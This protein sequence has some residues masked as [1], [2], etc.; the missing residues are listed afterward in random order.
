MMAEPKTDDTTDL[1]ALFV[2]ARQD[3]AQMP[4]GLSARMMADA[5][6]I[7]AELTAPVAVTRPSNRRWLHLRDLLG[8]WPG[9]GGLAAACAAGVWLGFAPPALFPDP[10][11]LISQTETDVDLFESDSL[12]LAFLEEN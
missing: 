2:T 12:V 8:G 3:G 1:D 6:Q 9:F 11:Q 4:N 7:Q 5:M 10:V